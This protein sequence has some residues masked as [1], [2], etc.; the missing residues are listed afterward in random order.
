MNPA[1]LLRFRAEIARSLEAE[2]EK[3]SDGDAA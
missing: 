2:G 3:G 1:D